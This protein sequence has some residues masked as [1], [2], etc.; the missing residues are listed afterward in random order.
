M[1]LC[2]SKCHVLHR[3]LRETVD[4]VENTW[5]AFNSDAVIVTPSWFQLS[6]RAREICRFQF[7]TFD[8]RAN[9][10]P[11]SRRSRKISQ[12][13]SSIVLMR[14]TSWLSYV[15]KAFI[16]VQRWRLVFAHILATL[17][18]SIDLGVIGVVDA[19]SECIHRWR[20]HWRKRCFC[21]D[22]QAQWDP[23]TLKNTSDSS[24]FFFLVE[25]TL[26]SVVFTERTG[27]VSVL[28]CFQLHISSFWPLTSQPIILNTDHLSSPRLC[29]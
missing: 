17:M 19:R 29:K 25:V 5:T 27:Q 6:V 18:L 8:A 23:Q 1:S 2:L 9:N 12:M 11:P 15:V 24:I 20:G 7:V 28:R 26:I 14:L 4:W 3:G 21:D 13:A 16:V 10:E 22:R